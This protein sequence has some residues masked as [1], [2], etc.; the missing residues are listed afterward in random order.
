[1]NETPCEFTCSCTGNGT[2]YTIFSGMENVKS[3]SAAIASGAKNNNNN[4]CAKCKSV[5]D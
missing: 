4:P 2:S 3:A 5:N 1:M